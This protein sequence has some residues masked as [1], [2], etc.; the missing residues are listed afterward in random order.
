MDAMLVAGMDNNILKEKLKCNDVV[1]YLSSINACGITKIDLLHYLLRD[2]RL[3]RQ[4]IN[5]KHWKKPKDTLDKEA[6]YDS[7]VIMLKH[8]FMCFKKVGMNAND[9]FETY[10]NKNV[11]NQYRQEFGY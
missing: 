4:H 5:W 3:V 10:V 8:L 9:V 7:Y 2:L 1:E 11:E 6:L